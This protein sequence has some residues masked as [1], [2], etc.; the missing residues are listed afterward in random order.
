MKITDCFWE[1]RNL[2][3]KVFE[4]SIENEDSIDANLL[5]EYSDIDYLVIKVPVN[6]TDINFLLGSLG[7]SLVEM[8]MEMTVL[9]KDF[10]FDHKLIKWVLP[11]VE[12]R[13]VNNQAELLDLLSNIKT[14]MFSTDRICLDPY[15]GAEKGCIRYKN[16]IQDEFDKKT[17]NILEFCYRGKNVGF[18]MYREAEI[19]RGLLGGIYP[20][21][22]QL[23]LGLLTPSSLPLYVMKRG[24]PIKKIT[25]NISSNNK[26]VWELYE[27]FGYQVKNPQYVFV[28]HKK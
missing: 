28:K 21:Y 27:S 15:Y 25:A 20:E 22:Q 5:K 3:D 2:G 26:P 17:S 8:Q 1:K 19:T 11:Y 7:F 16:W 18:M 24:L 14:S 4:I 13:S 12:F 10:N 6:K 9:M 23:A